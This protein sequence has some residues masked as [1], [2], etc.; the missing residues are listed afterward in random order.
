MDL[1]NLDT[2]E[3]A[4][5][6]VDVPL[7]IEGETQAGLDGEPITFRL[8]GIADPEIKRI[9]TA[10]YKGVQTIEDF[11]KANR[12]VALAACIGWSGNWTLDGEKGVPFSKEAL[13]KVLEIPSIAN[14]L[15]TEVTKS[16]NFMKKP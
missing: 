7:V 9:A 11:E 10:A 5:E 2:R 15:A 3:R 4:H 13:A 14:A 8:R 1:R 6:G 16:V 12:K